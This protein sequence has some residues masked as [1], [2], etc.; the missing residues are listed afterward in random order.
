MIEFD[1]PG[2]QDDRVNS[3]T[4]YNFFFW[5]V[6]KSL[7]FSC[8]FLKVGSTIIKFWK[9]VP[10]CQRWITFFSPLINALVLALVGLLVSY[11]TYQTDSRAQCSLRDIH[12]FHSCSR[13]RLHSGKGISLQRE[14]DD[15]KI[16]RMWR[17]TF[18]STY[19]HIYVNIF[20]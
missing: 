12:T 13:R 8:G 11:G 10:F 1:T 4:T 19:I 5:S 17:C 2:L 3:N 7:W 16:V 14:G 15:I 9:Y 18:S 6:T 20:I